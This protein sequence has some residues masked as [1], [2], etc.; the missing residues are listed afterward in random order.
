MSMKD[1]VALLHA[2]TG[3]GAIIASI[4]AKGQIGIPEEPVKSLGFGIFVVGSL[5]FAWSLLHLRGAFTG[6]VDP[7]TNRLV[8]TG[9]YRFVRHPVYLAMI[10]MV[11][12]LA[13]GLRSVLGIAL[14]VL[15][16]IPSAIC[17]ARLEEA[18]LE[19]KF[20]DAWIAYRSRTRFILP[21]IC[22]CGLAA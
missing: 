16:F 14:I 22:W 4:M 3:A 20:G 15:T 10:G 19:E 6:N 7:V 1:F 11:F 21:L 13:I 18:A 17:R 9:P 12:G 2:L 8:T 5:L